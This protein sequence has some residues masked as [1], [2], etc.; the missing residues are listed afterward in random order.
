M[1]GARGMRGARETAISERYLYRDHGLCL[2]QGESCFDVLD[3][4]AAKRALFD[5]YVSYAT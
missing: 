1:R 2:Q 4:F 5:A 3:V